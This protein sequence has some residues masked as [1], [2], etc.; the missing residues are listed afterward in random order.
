MVRQ[1]RAIGVALLLGA[2]GLTGCQTKETIVDIETPNG[3]IEVER[4]RTT[5]DTDVKINR[6]P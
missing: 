4:D 2:I 5:G 6:N 1:I 3:D